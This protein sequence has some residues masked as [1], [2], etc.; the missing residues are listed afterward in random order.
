MRS[1]S[2][3]A[4]SPS[5]PQVTQSA[6][7]VLSGDRRDATILQVVVAAVERLLHTREL[8]EVPGNDLLHE[9]ARISSGGRGQ[10]GELLLNFGRELHF[11]T[12]QHRDFQASWQCE[13]APL[14]LCQFEPSGSIAMNRFFCS[15]PVRA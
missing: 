13:W 11:H 12:A 14:P 5:F 8:L 2:R 4:G 15:K 9:V 10:F 7:R 3:H 1:G 6:A